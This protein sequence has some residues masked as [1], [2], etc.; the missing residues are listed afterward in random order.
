MTLIGSHIYGKRFLLI[1]VV[2]FA[3]LTEQ[4][5]CLTVDGMNESHICVFKPDTFWAY[6]WPITF[7]Y[8]QEKMA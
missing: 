2:C 3:D 4:H 7:A 5:V 6:N 8:H 1:W